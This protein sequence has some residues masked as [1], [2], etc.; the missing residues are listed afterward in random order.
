MNGRS[1]D[2]QPERGRTRE[3]ITFCARSLLRSINN[4]LYLARAKTRFNFSLILKRPINF[5]A[6]CVGDQ[7]QVIANGA[8]QNKAQ[9]P[10][11]FCRPSAAFASIIALKLSQAGVNCLNGGA[12]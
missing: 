9:T 7:H 12:G 8:S 3:K 10:T 11:A 4:R 1:A 6:G 5:I 2:L